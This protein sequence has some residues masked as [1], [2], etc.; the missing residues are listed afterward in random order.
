MP[1]GASRISLDRFAEPLDATSRPVLVYTY[2][3][4]SLPSANPVS[5]CLLDMFFSHRLCSRY[6]N[7]TWP[8]AHKSDV[9]SHLLGKHLSIENRESLALTRHSLP[10]AHLP[11]DRIM[12]ELRSF[13]LRNS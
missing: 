10:V 5:R 4:T 9:Y 12:M 2:L 7:Q 13:F 1:A 11:I 3:Y 8:G 6:H